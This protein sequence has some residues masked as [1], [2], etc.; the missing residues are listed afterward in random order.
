MHVLVAGCGWLGTALSRR[1]LGR[2]DR[3][4]GVRSDPARAEALRPLGITPLALDLADPAAADALPADIEAVVACQ[5][6]GA[7]GEE[8][9]RRA[10]LAA[11]RTLLRAARDRPVRALVYTGSTGLFGQR[12]G[13]DVDERTPPAPA[14]PGGRILAEAEGLILEAAAGGLPA[15]LLRLSGLYGPGRTWMID[16][17][18][19]GGFALG[20][21]DDAFLNSCHQDDAVA[22]LLA[23]LDRG[24]DG[25]VYHATDAEP[26]RRAE[27]VTWVAGHLGI[28]PPRAAPGAAPPPGPNR[29]IHGQ[30]TRAEL[31]LALRWPSLREGLVPLLPP[32]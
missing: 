27:V 18:R 9:Y 25:G 3:V 6:S 14:T 28:P 24:R 19:S 11:N 29:R 15:R 8:A 5:S 7:E 17:V 26:L 12:D 1:L 31:G 2:G 23:V 4:T 21:G 13:S 10:Y 22:A 20:P 30:A 16:R 32:P